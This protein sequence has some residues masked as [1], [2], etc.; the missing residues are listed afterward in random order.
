MP[1]AA[2]WKVPPPRCSTG[3]FFVGFGFAD[4]EGEGGADGEASAVTGADSGEAAW[5]CGCGCGA[6]PQPASASMSSATVV[7]RILPMAITLCGSGFR[8]E[9]LPDGDL[10]RSGDTAARAAGARPA[11]P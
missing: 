2:V 8:R 9:R 5:N 6:L 4:G 10:R 1:P 3:V 11:P 7:T